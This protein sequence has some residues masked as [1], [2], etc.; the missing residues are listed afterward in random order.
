MIEK[1]PAKISCDSTI[2]SCSP[3]MGGLAIKRANEPSDRGFSG[4][5]GY[6]AVDASGNMGF[7]TAGHVVEST[8]TVMYHYDDTVVGTA[9]E[10][11]DHNRRTG[12]YDVAF[13]RT[14][15][16]SDNIFKQ[17]NNKKDIAKKIL[18]RSDIRLGEIF[19]KSG[20]ATGQETS[21][22]VRG[23]LNDDMIYFSSPSIFGD[24]G[25]TVYDYDKKGKVILWG[26]LTRNTMF[27]PS[28]VIENTYSI[29][30]QL[31]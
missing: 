2:S 11:Y 21:S 25:G 26:H 24:S 29:T 18:Q 7:V 20:A 27:V 4:S 16:I 5:V 23:F 19:Y 22:R 3:L 31:R 17:S 30:P 9:T 10:K 13:V 15:D 6:K 8:G 1:F 12:D 28:F 14:S